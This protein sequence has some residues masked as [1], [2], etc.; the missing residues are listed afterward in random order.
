[1]RLSP[2]LQLKWIQVSEPAAEGIQFKVTDVCLLTSETSKGLVTGFTVFEPRAL[3]EQFFQRLQQRREKPESQNLKFRLH[4]PAFL[5]HRVDTLRVGNENLLDEV[6]YTSFVHVKCQ[7]GQCTVRTKLRVVNVD[8]SPVLLKFL[9][10][11][12]E[13]LGYCEVVDQ[14]SDP[15][16]AAEKILELRPDVVTMDIQMPGMT[17]VQVV[18]KVLQ[19]SYFPILMISSLNMEEGSLVFSALNAG[20]FDYLQKP[21]LEDK[22]GFTKDLGERLLAAVSSLQ[23]KVKARK[24]VKSSPSSA[25][26]FYYPENLIWCLGSSTGGTQALTHVFTSMPTSIPPTLIVQHIPPVFSKSFADS[27]NDLCP[28]KVKEAEDGEPIL[29]N[30]V[31]IAP[32]GQ[33]M[34]VEKKLGKLHVVL[35]DDPPVNRFKPSVDYMFGE[36]AKLKGLQIVGAILTGMGRDG[37]KGLLELK[38]LGAR[39]VAQDEESSAVFGMPRAAIEEGAAESV[40]PL[41]NIANAMLAMSREMNKAS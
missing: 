12:L 3:T 31:Y 28:F 20:A 6:V 1:M 11:S 39:T 32:G 2:K 36:V 9:K 22:D 38:K 7:S 34:G 19:S 18:E 5:S 25:P 4:A 37:A 10:H 35:R 17:G 15:L 29:P 16:V 13:S 41:D 23:S 21:K 40:E 30:H 24:S 27:L 14:V 26:S 8:D 33:Q